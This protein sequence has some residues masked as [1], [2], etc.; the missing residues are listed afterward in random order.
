MILNI[1]YAYDNVQLGHLHLFL[2]GDCGAQN[3]RELENKFKEITSR[4]TPKILIVESDNAA[5]DPSGVALWIDMVSRYFSNSQ[6][7]YKPSQLCLCLKY[8]DSYT[9]SRPN[10]VFIDD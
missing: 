3:K 5:V 2:E 6:M 1:T 10:D 8:D 7:I 9:K 4:H